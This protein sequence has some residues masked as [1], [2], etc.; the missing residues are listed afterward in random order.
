MSFNLDK[1]E[2][3]SYRVKISSNAT[4]TV[5]EVRKPLEHLMKGKIVTHPGLT[6]SILQLLYSREGIVL[7]KSLQ[8]ETGTYILHEKHS[9]NVKVFGP[10]D[11]VAVVEQR[12]VQSLLL[13]H[14]NKQL[15]ICLR[16]RHLPN[17]LLKE[18]VQRFGP[19]LH[20]L[21][22]KV[23][24]TEFVL[25]T[26]RHILSVRGNK[27]LK[28]KVEEIVFE[29]V[30]SLSD[31]PA[32]VS[33]GVA[34][35]S[36]CLCEIEDCYQLEGCGHEFC[37]MCMIDQCESMIRNRDGFPLC[38]AYEG[39]K[40]KILLVDLRC[41]LPADKLEELFRA[42]LGAF[43]A[44][45]GGAYRFCP[46][47]DCPAVYRA[48]DPDSVLEQPPFACGACSVETCRKCHMEY[49]PPFSCETYREIKDDPD[50]SLIEWRKGKENVKNCLGCN[51]TIE[52][53]VGCNHIMCKC[54]RHICW[55]CLESFQTGEECYAH[56]GE[57]HHG[58]T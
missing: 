11:A 33:S 41:L 15:Q 20:G 51:R 44:S 47:P 10:L 48:V 24:G 6:P 58:I 42:S 32:D 39:C 21:M 53:D 8:R 3:G 17:T 31:N 34:M 25:D 16:G 50:K 23:P 13:L 9:M 14:E 1:N 30:Q 5:A 28:Q 45:S 57:V 29:M 27:E 37:R 12:L 49:H 19:D 36:I 22:E 55:V 52:K 35:C 18:V 43:V 40:S 7:M 2:N 46:S 56:L 54:G 4:K 38:C 26:R